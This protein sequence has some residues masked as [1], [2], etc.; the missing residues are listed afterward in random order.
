[1]K[2]PRSQTEEKTEVVAATVV[3]RFVNSNA[4]AEQANPKN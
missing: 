1:M 2:G 3:V 4:L